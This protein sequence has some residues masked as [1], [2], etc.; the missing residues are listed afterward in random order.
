MGPVPRKRSSGPAFTVDFPAPLPAERRGEHWWM[1]ADG[2]ELRLSNLDKVFWPDE[3]Y[4]KGDLIAFYYNVSE[5]IL[6][7]LRG[8]PLTMK[9]MPNGVAGHFFYEKEAPSH[10]PDWMSRCP[11]STSGPDSRWG[12][13]KHDVI[14]Y[15]MVENVA[16]LLFMANLAC[17]EFHPLHSRCASI[18]EPDYVFF[19]LDPFEPAT[20]DDVLAVAR[21]VNVSC[22]RLGLVAYPKT[23]G[24]TGMQIYVPIERGFSYEETRALV[25]ALGS[26]MRKADPDRVTMEW[27]VRKRT[28]KVF[29][30]HNMNRVGANISA[31]WSMRPEPGATVSTPVSWEEVDAARIRPGDFTIATIWERIA[32]VG[33]PFRPVVEEPQ[34]LAPALAALGIERAAAAPDATAPSRRRSKDDETIARSKDPNLGEYLRKRSFGDAGTPEP[35]SG[36]PTAGGNSFVIQWHD[37]TRLH[38][39]FRLERGGVLVSWAVPKGLPWEHGERHLAVQTE[40]HPME[41]GSFSGSIPAGHYGAG[42][43]RIWDAGTYDLLEWTTDKVSVRLHGRRHT[44]EYHLIKTKTD[45]LVLL[46]KSSDVAPPESPPALSPMLA[47]PGGQPFDRAGWLFEPKLDGIRTLLS[48]DRQR[49]RLISRTGRDQTASYPELHNLFRR[50]VAVNALIDGEIVAGDAEGKPSFERLQQ[51]M[52][53]ASPSEIERAAKTIPVELFAFDVLWL[54]GE[55]MTGL[56]LSGR[57]ERLLEVA[58][59]GKGLRLV[60]GVT[61]KGKDFYEGA[62]RLGLEG[63][64]A[65]RLSSRYAPGRRTP[66]WKKI[67]ILNRQ[68]CVVLGW[69]PG[70]GGRGSSFGALLLGAYADGELRWIGQVGTGFTDRML[71]DLQER[72]NA[73]ETD[74]PALDDPEIAKVRGVHW[75]RPELVCEVEFLQITAAFKLRAPSF[76][77]L[78]PDKAP[79]DAVLE[80]VATPAPTRAARAG[81]KPKAKPKAKPTAGTATRG[82]RSRRG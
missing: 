65:K 13:V 70:Q 62:K 40:D 80:P 36:G 47:E 25:G 53:L 76:K 41:Y 21:L 33:D 27:E 64:V 8:R 60:P 1:E 59:E 19:D 7:Y 49:V 24:A 20:Y 28:G 18:D 71:A 82:A 17:I 50:V 31:A 30:D 43:V 67:K 32:S 57:R 79:Q 34:D 58:V 38:H 48:F 10:T 55:D 44:G 22:D 77:G 56:P 46:A 68:D 51:R 29:V 3:G 37:A 52:N 6:P 61:A 23:S 4:T 15:L 39:D 69:T 16:G 63:V 75:V 26:L 54:D 73:I 72:L 78:R 81:P 35:E 45:W 66:D 14:N 74:R 12:P 42:E 11:V 9:R 2:R 5:Q